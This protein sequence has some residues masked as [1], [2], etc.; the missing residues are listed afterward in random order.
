MMVDNGTEAALRFWEF[1][2]RKE[3]V[4]GAQFELGNKV[5]RWE[6]TLDAV[7]FVARGIED[8][9]GWRPLRVVTFAKLL[10]CFCLSLYVHAHR[11]EIVHHE[12][13]DTSVRIHL[14]I[15]PSTAASHRRGAEIK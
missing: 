5:L 2:V 13:R 14:G 12:G 15:Q 4:R 7:T 6:E 9:N 8:Q 1:L 11:D 10:E 3:G